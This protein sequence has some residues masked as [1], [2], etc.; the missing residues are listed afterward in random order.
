[1]T[2]DARDQST[3]SDNGSG[4]ER[5]VP[6]IKISKNKRKNSKNWSIVGQQSAKN[7]HNNG[8]AKNNGLNVDN[9]GNDLV[10]KKR[11]RK[12]KLNNGF[13][14]TTDEV[15]GHKTNKKQKRCI[16]DKKRMEM[17]Y[18]QNTVEEEVETV[19]NDRKINK[20][21]TKWM[22]NCLIKKVDTDFEQILPNEILIKIFDYILVDD[23]NRTQS[24]IK[25]RVEYS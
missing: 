1:M 8:N 22:L 15:N 11:G 5:T 16:N 14:V 6:S 7:C 23:H 21:H 25:K 17:D 9:N 2:S 24:I 18:K 20:M 12:P 3:A 4:A 13:T 19:E 10:P